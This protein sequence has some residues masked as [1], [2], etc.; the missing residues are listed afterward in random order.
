MYS[1]LESVIDSKTATIS[2]CQ[3]PA[4]LNLSKSA[5]C[6]ASP[7]IWNNLPETV[8]S[9]I[10]VSTVTFKSGLKFKLFYTVVRSSTDM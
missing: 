9:D 5:F 3:R 4:V 6:H 7:T 2:R 10:T 8:V 1:I